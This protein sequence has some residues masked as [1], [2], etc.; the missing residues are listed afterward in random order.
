[1]PN[2]V[3]RQFNPDA[4]LTNNWHNAVNSRAATFNAYEAYRSRLLPFRSIKSRIRG[5][6]GLLRDSLRAP[7]GFA[8]GPS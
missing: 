6:E 4:L 3:G 8:G 7:K 5:R 1:M 2:N